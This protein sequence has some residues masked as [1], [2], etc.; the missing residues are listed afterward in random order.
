MP[1]GAA[2][3]VLY[4]DYGAEGVTVSVEALETLVRVAGLTVELLAA[5]QGIKPQNAPSQ[6]AQYAKPATAPAETSEDP[7]ES[8]SEAAQAYRVNEDYEKT[9]AVE[10]SYDSSQSYDS[11]GRETETV[12]ESETDAQPETSG[13]EFQNQT[14]SEDFQKYYREFET[15]EEEKSEL[16]TEEKTEPDYSYNYQP[17]NYQQNSFDKNEES[18]V[19]E[20]IIVDDEEAR[21]VEFVSETEESAPDYSTIPGYDFESAPEQSS[22]EQFSDTPRFE[23]ILNESEVPQ[24][25]STNDFSEQVYEKKTADVESYSRNG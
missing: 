3:A 15:A 25:E 7:V 16:P 4:A 21:P 5:S 12:S 19:I 2:S 9:E 11:S 6:A 14:V 20:E 18:I 1:A 8:E 17:D 24:F 10:E 22:Q 23:E 13:Y